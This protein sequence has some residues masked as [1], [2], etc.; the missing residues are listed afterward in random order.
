MRSRTGAGARPTS[1]RSPST[2]GIPVYNALTDEWHPTQ[3]LA[4]FLTMRESSGKDD[5][6]LRYAFVGDLRFNMGRSLLVMGALMGSDVRLVGPA[7]RSRHPPRS[8]RPLAGSRRHGPARASPITDDIAAGVEGVDFLHTD[9]WMS[10]GEPIDAW[11][12][13]VALLRPFQVDASDARADGQPR[14]CDSCTA[15]RRTTTSAP[16]SA[17]T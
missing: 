7:R 14:R 16:R 2:A 1:R 11:R 10:M 8:S 13:R 9:V 12:E 5:A 3:M 4:D 6:D 15:C 17:G